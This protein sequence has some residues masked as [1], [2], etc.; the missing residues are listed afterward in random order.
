[1]GKVYFFCDSQRNILSAYFLKK[2][3]FNSDEYETIL[4]VSNNSNNSVAC[5]QRILKMG[6][7]KQVEIIEEAFKD[8]IYLKERAEYYKINHGDIVGVFA[9]QNRFARALY[10]QA[11]LVDASVML[12]DEGV[13]LFHDFIN[14]QKNHRDGMFADID[15]EKRS[16]IAWCYD[17]QMY[18]LPDNF[19]VKR[20]KIREYLED[21]ILCKKMQSEIKYIFNVQNEK[22]A[23]IIYFDQYYALSG[24]TSAEIERYFLE[25]ISIICS[26]FD[27]LIKPHP[28]ERGFN[29]K[30]KNISGSIMQSQNSPWEAIYFVNY[31]KQEN[32]KLICIAGESTAISSPLLMFGDNNY[33]LI[34]LKDIYNSFILSSTLW[35]PDKYFDTL[36]SLYNENLYMPNS[37]GQLDYVIREIMESGDKREN[38]LLNKTEMTLSKLSKEVIGYK[39][40]VITPQ[41]QVLDNNILLESLT[42]E[43]VLK[44]GTFDFSYEIPEKT[45]RKENRFRWIPHQKCFIRFKNLRITIV[46]NGLEEELMIE[47]FIP[48][49]TIVLTSDGYGEL[50][51][52]YPSFIIKLEERKPEKIRIRGTWKF[53]FNR[54]RVLGALQL[55]NE[56]KVSLLKSQYEDKIKQLNM[57]ID[58]LEK[59][60]KKQEDT[61]G[62]LK[63]NVHN[64]KKNYDLW[65]RLDNKSDILEQKIDNLES[66]KNFIFRKK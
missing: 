53:D 34:I 57:N 30:Y 36:R 24:R 65:E 48:E 21:V 15:V 9:L 17:P 39:P 59:I 60:I 58:N 64:L 63:D 28:M 46:V 29:E 41:L 35:S 26:S 42:V 19:D 56:Q 13:I 18:N 3:Y 10:Q 4:L 37:F 43:Y 40:T 62:V 52:C 23:Q 25:M 47:N 32:K 54:E 1:M 45:F 50:S 11:T 6:E 51:S 7:W 20:I 22:A 55:C 16:I 12:I 27:F 49:Q 66:R 2:I 38:E 31:Y 33:K 44:D 61:I 5:A 14:W 8:E